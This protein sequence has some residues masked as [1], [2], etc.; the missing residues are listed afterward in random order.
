M[1]HYLA[2]GAPQYLYEHF[3]AN[4]ECDVELVE[5]PL[6]D[7][8]D[9]YT[10]I[11]CHP[12]QQ[13]DRESTV[14]LKYGYLSHLFFNIFFLNRKNNCLL[15]FGVN[16]LNFLSAY[17]AKKLGCINNDAKLIYYSIDF[18][19]ER[20][21]N[22]YANWVY[23]W[24]ERFS[25]SKADKVWDVS[26]MINRARTEHPVLLGLRRGN[27]DS[28]LVVPIGVERILTRADSARGSG[29][30]RLGFV[31]HLLEK[32][33]LG[34]VLSA[35][36]QHVSRHEPEYFELDII[37]GG[38]CEKELKNF[39]SDNQLDG[40][41]KFHGWIHSRKDIEDILRKCDVG[42]AMYNPA[43]VGFTRYADPTKLKD[44]LAVGLPIVMTAT[45]YNSSDL[46]EVGCAFEAKFNVD[47]FLRVL[48][49]LAQKPSVLRAAHQAIPEVVGS[50]TWT[51]IFSDA[52]RDLAN[53]K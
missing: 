10:K 7:D 26:P 1:T 49:T 36:R 25:W 17:L 47:D 8:T 30:L 15:V 45:T 23:H 19:P 51:K 44:Y 50:L 53:E 27:V 39:V 43:T 52:I 11:S 22:R 32:Q 6:T 28:P 41:V 20:F 14:K 48:R 37:G 2:K 24:I 29:A 40:Y 12:I 13:V 21:K 18:S 31:G 35:L 34:L 5:H 16:P 4:S 3:V 42:L 9:S 38:G 46:F 33:G